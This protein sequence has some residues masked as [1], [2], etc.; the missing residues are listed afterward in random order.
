MN[1]FHFNYVVYCKN[2]NEEMKK[3]KT[4]EKTSMEKKKEKEAISTVSRTELIET[5]N[6]EVKDNA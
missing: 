5:Y 1:N 3:E 2:W 6:G 4:R